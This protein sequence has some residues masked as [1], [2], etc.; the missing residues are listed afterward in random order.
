MAGSHVFTPCISQITSTSAAPPP[1]AYTSAVQAGDVLWCLAWINDAAGT[2]T[3]VSDSVN[4]AW[5]KAFGPV[6]G[7]AA[8][9]NASLYGWYRVNSSAGT[10]TLTVATSSNRAGGYVFGAIR[11]LA[12]GGALDVGIGQAPVGPTTDGW[13][14]AS[15]ALAHAGAAGIGMFIAS[16]LGAGTVVSR[17]TAD[18]SVEWAWYERVQ[19]TVSA[20]TASTSMGI[21]GTTTGGGAVATMGLMVFRD[22][23]SD[24]PP[25]IT[26]QPTAQAV[27]AGATATFS[28]A[29]SGSPIPTWQWQRSTN[30][31]STWSNI[32]GAVAASYTTPATSISGGSANNA[33]QYRAVATN[34]AGSATSAAAVLTVTAAAPA[35]AA[36]SGAVPIVLVIG[37]DGKIGL[38]KP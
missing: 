19:R 8:N 5:T 13:E 38:M 34:S 20:G 4:G 23:V 26:T 11:G 3:G 1:K 9:G 6:R 33:D 17:W 30:G 14:L 37:L 12:G 22:V 28:A 16:T 31:G 32:A 2:V 27:T 25:S 15:G 35:P 21:S 7:T 18:L 24:T 36:T 10:P 29:S